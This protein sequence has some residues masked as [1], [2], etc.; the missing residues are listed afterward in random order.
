MTTRSGRL[1]HLEAA[2]DERG[3]HGVVIGVEG[4]VAL[5]IDE[6]LMEQ[7][8]LG[9]PAG[10]AAQGRV[11]DGEEL[12]R[13]GLEVALGAGVD[14]ITPGAGLAVGV[15]PVGEA[16]AGEKAPLDEAEHPLD[17][18]GAI[19]V[20]D[21]VG[22][23]GEAEALGEG[24]HLGHGDHVPPGALE[25][26]H[27]GVVD[28]AG[29]A[30]AVHVAKGLGEEDLA[31]EAAEPGVELEEEHAGVAEHEA[32]GLHAPHRAA[33]VQ[34]R[35]ARCRAASPGRARSRSARPAAG[36][37]WPIPWRRQKAVKAG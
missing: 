3:G 23:E 22:D 19:G 2:A 36:G 25:H 7:V 1:A 30:G 20:A 28:H 8:G 10:Q 18:P 16:P 15:G 6:P 11:L 14:A 17:A 33:E 35:A 13:G 4:D 21:G 9:D 31:L 26:D 34:R 37:A 5:D 27:V 29:L 12:A 32:G 24:G